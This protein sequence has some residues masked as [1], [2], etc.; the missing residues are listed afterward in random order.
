[1]LRVLGGWRGSLLYSLA[2]RT[3]LD[4]SCL[5]VRVDC[6]YGGAE[7]GGVVWLLGINDIII[8][9]FFL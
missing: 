8:L 5:L 1:V 6:E 2:D 3:K 7:K 9:W 4:T